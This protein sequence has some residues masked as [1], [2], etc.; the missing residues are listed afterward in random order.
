MLCKV[1]KETGSKLSE[2]VKDIEDYPQLLENVTITEKARGKWS[3]TPEITEKISEAEKQLAGEGRV[4]VRES[5]TE[6][7]LRIMLEGKNMELVKRLTNEIAD[8]VKKELC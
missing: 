4:L 5:G 8:V 2:L 3:N 7:L 1:L 6:P